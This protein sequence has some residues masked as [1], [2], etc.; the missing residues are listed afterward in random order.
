MATPAEI[1]AQV[2]LEREQI[3]QGLE[4]L[5][6]NTTKLQDKEYAS[7]TAYGVASIEQ[8]LPL[9]VARIQHTALDRIK[10]GKTGRCFAEIQ[11]YL[12]N[13]EAEAAAAIACKVVFDK[14][15][16]TKKASAMPAG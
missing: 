1:S 11:Q 5:R 7:A 15:F 13:I 3:R 16:A 8:L 4:K 6:D 9:V 14:V 12:A 10:K 2:D